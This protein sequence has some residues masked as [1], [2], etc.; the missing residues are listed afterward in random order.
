MDGLSR[1]TAAACTFRAGGRT[2]RL[3]P[4]TLADYGE[5]ENRI[6]ASRPDPL[7]GVRARLAGRPADERREEL[8]RALDQLCAMRRVTLG[9]LDRW[10][11][12]PD[13][14]CY[15]FWLMLR[16]EQP[17]MTLEAAAAV[18]RRTDVAGRAEIMRRMVDC[19]GW[20]DPWPA[21]PATAGNE[22]DEA[23]VPWVRWAVAL[24]RAYGWS[25][26][27]IGRLTV[28]QVC[29]YLGRR[30]ESVSPERMSLSEG[31]AL[32]RRR[33]DERRRWIEQM[34][35]ELA[36]H[37][38]RRA[39]APTRLAV[40]ELA[41]S[42]DAR[43]TAPIPL[44]GAAPVP[45]KGPFPREVP[46]SDGAARPP[47]HGHDWQPP[48][49]HP[50]AADAGDSSRGPSALPSAGLGPLRDFVKDAATQSNQVEQI[51]I[52]RDQLAEQRKTNQ[53]LLRQRGAAAVFE[54]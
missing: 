30:R 42:A 2:Y 10:W 23:A 46:A 33:L 52:A 47:A 7:R 29:I 24:G 54:P 51:R 31:E 5:I 21:A 19:H 39:P 15:R 11:Q 13:G 44:A 14:L 38:D 49:P 36:E 6:V 18:L 22:E 40:E 28:A 34:M 25:P 41:D 12:T 35:E 37:P 48:Q 16:K 45:E 43:A 8:G 1:L 27:E 32:C 9:D 50:A 26:A 20:P 53:H 17:G 4:L 3:A